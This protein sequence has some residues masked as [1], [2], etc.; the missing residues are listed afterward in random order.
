MT[1]QPAQPLGGSQAWLPPIWSS[2]LLPRQ[3]G[4]AR[5][6]RRPGWGPAGGQWSPGLGPPAPGNRTSHS[7]HFLPG[8]GKPVPPTA[9]AP[10][11]ST[12][13]AFALISTAGHLWGANPGLGRPAPPTTPTS[14]PSP[15]PKVQ[16]HPLLPSVGPLPVSAPPA[17]PSSPRVPQGH[18]RHPGPAPT[19]PWVPLAPAPLRPGLPPGLCSMQLLPRWLRCPP[20]DPFTPRCRSPDP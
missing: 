15:A 1:Q 7:P 6:S 19:Q 13:L 10:R 3:P 18:L 5:G 17:Q 8:L 16:H 12:T 2:W 20:S 11:A 14:Q 9:S 4:S